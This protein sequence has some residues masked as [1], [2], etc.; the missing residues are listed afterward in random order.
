M[1]QKQNYKI[2][3]KNVATVHIRDIRNKSPTYTE[4][5]LTQPLIH[6]TALIQWKLNTNT[7]KCL[8][9]C[10][11]FFFAGILSDISRTDI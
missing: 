9:F 7:N 3:L 8:I 6:K 11:Y 10:L 5:L 1:L 4:F 2:F